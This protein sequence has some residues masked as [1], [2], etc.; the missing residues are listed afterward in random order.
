VIPDLDPG[1]T[2]RLLT[3]SDMDGIA[4]AALLAARSA[5]ES[6]SFAHPKDVRDGLVPVEAGDIMAHLPY[7]PGV[8]LAFD[9]KPSDVERLGLAPRPAR[10]VC[11]ESAPSAARVVWDHFGGAF[12]GVAPALVA[13]ADRFCAAD[14][15]RGEILE[16][17]GWALLATIA[18]PRTGLGRFRHFTVSNYRLMER[19]VGLAA[20]H[21]ERVETIL[22]D[23]DMRERVTFLWDHRADFEAQIRRCTRLHPGGL[24]V[25]DLRGEEVI[26]PGSRF[27]LYA[28]LPEIRVSCHVFWGRNRQNTVFALG[29]SLFQAKANDVDLGAL[30]LEHGGD[31]APGAGTCQVDNAHAE[32]VLANFVICLSA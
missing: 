17:S 8:H 11:D 25:L 26:W 22:A 14:F 21:S 24:G 13:A 23:P 16:P 4:C 31:G 1:R 18:D 10:L 6:V 12:P 15:A 5:V 20:A 29:R 7:V 28:L 27:A 19:L 30:C 2:Y 9:N 3:R 32:E